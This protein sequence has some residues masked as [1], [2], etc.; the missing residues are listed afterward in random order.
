MGLDD[1]KRKRSLV[2]LTKELKFY[3]RSKQSADFGVCM[4]VCVGCVVCM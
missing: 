2:A 3:S 4:C 1:T